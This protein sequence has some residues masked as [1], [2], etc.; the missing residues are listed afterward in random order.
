MITNLLV[1]NRGEIASRIFR[2]CRMVGIGTV[3]VYAEPD[4]GLPFVREADV[5]VALG[6]VSSAE[7][8][9]VVEKILDAARRSGADAIHPGFG[10]LS[11]NAEFA[12][13]VIAAGFVWVGP[14]PANI[15]AMGSKMEAKK[16]AATARVP[17]LPWAEVVG[18][19]HSQW[20]ASADEVKYP[21]LVKATAGGGG[22]GMRIVTRAEELVEAVASARR[23]A[24]ASFGD[25]RVFMERY[26]P[27]PRHIEFQVFG[28][29]HGNVIHL[30]EREC[31]IQRRFQKIVEEAP[32]TALSEATRREM[33]HDAVSLAKA[34]KYI[35]AGTVEFVYNDA[36]DAE[37]PSYYF[38]EMNTRLQVE[39]PVTECITGTD[40]VQWQID[41]ANGLPL[42]LTQSQVLWRGHAIEVR[43]YA[44]DAS[45]DF[46]P[47]YGHLR[48]YEPQLPLP[49]GIRFENGVESG[50]MISTSFDPMLAKV[51]S[52]APT[53]DLAAASL[54]TAL[55]ELTIHGITTNRDY[56]CA[57]LADADFLAGHTTTAFVKNHPE[58][59]TRA[60]APH[61]LCVHAIAAVLVGSLQR[62]RC[63]L[64]WGFADP[65]WRNL[66]SQRQRISYR[67]AIT[68]REN[69]DATVIADYAWTDRSNG[70][71]VGLNGEDASGQVLHTVSLDPHTDRITLTIDGLTYT[72]TVRVLSDRTW[73]NSSTAQTELI[74][75]PRFP[76]MSVNAAAA[77]P[78]APVP[79]RI[80][81]VSC[82]AG[83][84]VEAGQTL[85]VLEAMKMEHRIEAA[86]P[87]TVGEVLCAVG[88]Q[89]DA[90]QLLVRLDVTP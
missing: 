75:V 31:S 12:E 17:I 69:N 72:L 50:S 83:D 41:V 53:R 46:M 44:E 9:L 10:F 5:A 16:L 37:G 71:V 65:G 86:A 61:V 15:A 54:R 88:D 74:E 11:E 1:A 55:Q 20:L 49:L 57:V 68:S 78:M 48:A 24:K 76:M 8:Y 47:T 39:H 22:R 85:V 29:T 36:V 32:S 80:V 59:L 43:L 81:A 35:G 56:L 73:V 87:A 40:L 27:A 63:D 90:H 84:R 62:R 52:H 14:S 70:F 33:G 6:G 82:T 77:G 51:I 19:D 60:V 23:E 3:A 38:L 2:T 7:S 28:D 30:G 13:A 66:R 58:L 21:I 25:A 34:I 64:Q 18:E 45:A 79:G 67:E 26:L 42:P 4:A 89:V